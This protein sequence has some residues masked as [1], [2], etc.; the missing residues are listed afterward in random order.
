M[1]WIF[2]SSSAIDDS[3]SRFRAL[4]L[5]S[6]EKQLGGAPLVFDMKSILLCSAA[7]GGW[8]Q[9]RPRLRITS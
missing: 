4:S 1:S 8:R 9:P 2:S 6:I 5:L 7:G 3:K